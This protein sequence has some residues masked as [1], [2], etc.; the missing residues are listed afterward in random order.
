MILTMQMEKDKKDKCR[1]FLY[2]K[3]RENYI[4][5]AGILLAI[6]T[7]VCTGCKAEEAEPEIVGTVA[8]AEQ[9][10]SSVIETETISE[11]CSQSDEMIIQEEAE[12]EPIDSFHVIYQGQEAKNTVQLEHCDKVYNVDGVVVYAYYIYWP[13]VPEPFPYN[14]YVLYFQTPKEQVQLYPVKDFQVDEERG[15]L[16]TK[17]TGDDGFVCVQCFSLTEK[18]SSILDTKKELFND[19]QAEKMLCDAYGRNEENASDDALL[20]FSNVNMELTK[21]GTDDAQIL[22]GE[23]SGIERATGQRYY[24]DWEIDLSNNT[25]KVTPCIL[26]QYDSDKDREIFAESNRIFDKIEQG[27]WSEVEPIDGMEYLWGDSGG[28]WFRMDVNGDGL[29]ELLNGYA[30]Y[31]SEEEVTITYI[32]TYREQTAELVYVDVNDAMEFLFTTGNGNLVYEWC[33]SGGPCTSIARLCRFDIKWNKEYLD[34]LVRYRF[35]EGDGTDPDSYAQ[36]YPDTFGVG[37]YGTY[38]LRERKKTTEELA[39]NKDG[40]YTVRE[41]L[42]EKQFLNAYEQM[43]G[44]DFYQSIGI[45]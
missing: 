45:Y 25:Q 18:D 6:M 22:Y 17:I 7:A 10:A 23:V 19:K 44:L 16:Y 39:D 41:Y 26:K 20:K 11:E 15:I 37:G 38:Y 12:Q 43:T 40:K 1:N 2:N 5:T 36:D 21:M 28:D 35:P 30:S 4:K 31:Y 24:A 42:T 32:F 34:T 29:P 27:D 14:Q 8:E 3:K 9:S 13:F 33:V